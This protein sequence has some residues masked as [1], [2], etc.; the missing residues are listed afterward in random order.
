MDPLVAHSTNIGAPHMALGNSNMA[1]QNGFHS[2][3]LAHAVGG[4][5]HM[6]MAP[7]AMAGP[8]AAHSAAGN[9][10]HQWV[11]QFSSMQL[12]GNQAGPGQGMSM[13]TAPAR[14]NHFAAGIQHFPMATSYGM[15]QTNHPAGLQTANAEPT[16]DVEA[17]DRAFEAYDQDTKFD[18]EL[19]DWKR[20]QE[21]FESAQ[22]QWMAEHGPAQA[23]TAAEMKVIDAN[24]EELADELDERRAAGDPYVQPTVGPEADALRKKRAD[25][26][27]ARAATDIL[28][29]VAS[30][31]SEK[32]QN[33][34]F[35]ELMRRI[36]NHEVVVD[37]TELVDAETGE[38]VGGKG[39]G[40]DG[41]PGPSDMH[42]VSENH[43][44]SA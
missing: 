25:E 4:P 40:Q 5:V 13:N 11:D 28:A 15:A 44:H 22:D 20:Q 19:A 41:E 24:L 31:T 27:L 1:V 36:G 29:S 18:D 32:F 35:L 34:K 17:F 9:A 43:I 23:P 30:N 6:P 42:H 14:L 10:H 3:P 7:G 8:G 38:T 2:P 39:S 26:D 33:S 37:G 21:E 12:G 16:F